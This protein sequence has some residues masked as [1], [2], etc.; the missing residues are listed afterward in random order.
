MPNFNNPAGTVT[1]D[2][3]KRDI[4]A[5]LTGT[6]FLSSRTIIYG[7]LHYGSVRPPSCAPSTIPAW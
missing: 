4:V 2:D 6:T 5:T 7:D 1:S 3:A